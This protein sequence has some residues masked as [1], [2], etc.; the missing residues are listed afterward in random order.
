MKCPF[1]IH[2]INKHLFM[3]NNKTK[4]EILF[5]IH[6]NII[7]IY[8]TDQHI[9]QQYVIV[10]NYIPIHPIPR[11]HN[12]NCYKADILVPARDHIM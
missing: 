9:I 7:L 10:K 1:F 4:P 6:Q 3:E 12:F 8:V 11:Q 5:T 2:L